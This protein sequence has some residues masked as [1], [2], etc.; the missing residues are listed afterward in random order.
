MGAEGW[1]EPCSWYEK[2]IK[3]GEEFPGLSSPLP[4]SFTSKWIHSRG[5]LPLTVIHWC[6]RPP[7]LSSPGG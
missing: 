1:R 2:V 4:A 7:L 5:V 3:G 6:R